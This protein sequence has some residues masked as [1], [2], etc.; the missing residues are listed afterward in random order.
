MPGRRKHIMD[1]REF[2]RHIREGRSDRAIAHTLGVNRKTVAR[3]RAW[4]L[5]QGLLEG[6]LPELG[7]LQRLLD[8][9]I[10]A[11]PPPQ[12]VSTVEPYREIVEQ[13]HECGV[14]MA[15]IHT[16]LKERGYGGSYASVVRF[17]K[18]L[19]PA[20][21]ETVLRVETPPGEETQID[22]GYAG[23]M[24]DETG[25]P[26]K[27]WTFVATLSWSR[28]Q[29]VEF[30]FDQKSETWLRCHR[31]AFE[32]FGGVPERVVIDN[33]KAGIAK[34]CWDEPEGQHAYRECAMH[35]GFLI[36]PHKPG[37]PEHKGKVEQG[38]VHYVKRNFLAG[39]DPT[40]RAQANR[41]VLRWVE[42]T[43]GQRIHGTTREQP[44]E[45]F[46]VER[47]AL[48]PLPRS[49]YDLAV[50]KQ[51]KLHRDG[52]VVFEGSYYS[53]PF[54]LQG[55]KL[56]VRGGT[57]EVRIFTGEYQLVATHARAEKPG[58]RLTELSHLPA[59][60]LLAGLT[61]EQCQERAH[62][63]GP[64]T[65][66]LVERLLQHRPENRFRSAVRLLRLADRWGAKRLEGAC[67]RA[68]RF[69]ETSYTSIKRIL[70]QNLNAELHPEP[71][72]SPPASIFVRTAEELLEPL[73]GGEPWN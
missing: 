37:K 16:R 72:A 33:L 22:F 70:A 57:R 48:R 71:I 58:E 5:E 9:T 25:Q 46:E 59:H 2:I 28:H 14:E 62:A 17:V 12:N 6:V 50:W 68:L 61:R 65:A 27:A 55:Q 53:A 29:Y 66:E 24:L 38:G 30:V 39:R 19:H 21:P 64:A 63:I 52:Y 47:S 69:E 23:K 40:S 3:Y 20:V 7:D 54:R 1:I 43:A 44:L 35:Y 15:A 8:E 56:W 4:A 42:G 60:A 31:N 49:P 13:L 51:V 67:A 32:Y 36:D 34:R 10:N 11:P 41:D 26:R 73:M 18:R 45:R